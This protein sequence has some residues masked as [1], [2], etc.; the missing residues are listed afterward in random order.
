MGMLW[1]VGHAFNEISALIIMHNTPNHPT[2]L[3]KRLLG[4][5]LGLVRVFQQIYNYSSL[6]FK[7]R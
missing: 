3:V 4:G 1:L 7:R 2:L 6:L 5:S